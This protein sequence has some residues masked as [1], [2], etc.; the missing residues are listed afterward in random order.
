MIFSESFI[1]NDG[2][3]LFNRAAST[4]KSIIWGSVYTS[5]LDS[6]G[7][8]D[9][10]MHAMTSANFGTYTSSGSVTS[11]FF[12]T[13]SNISHIYCDLNNR[14]YDGVARTLGIWAKI[15]GDSQSVL[16]VVAR[17]GTGTV[18]TTV[19]PI[20]RGLLRVQVD[21]SITFTD[22]QAQSIEV[23][24]GYYAPAQALQENNN[25][26]SQIE[27]D[28]VDLDDRVTVLEED[29]GP[30]MTRFVS[31]HAQ[32]S[33]T[34]GDSQIIY[35]VKTFKD[36]IKTLSIVPDISAG[37][38]LGGSIGDLNVRFSYLFVDKCNTNTLV[39][40]TN[41]Y[42]NIQSSLIPIDNHDAA[43]GLGKKSQDV[44]YH[45]KDSDYYFTHAYIDTVYTHGSILPI[46][47]SSTSNPDSSIGRAYNPSA[48]ITS[49]TYLKL[50]SRGV[51]TNSIYAY[52]YSTGSY[53]GTS[54]VLSYKKRSTIQMITSTLNLT[55][56]GIEDEKDN[57]SNVL[58]DTYDVNIWR[59]PFSAGNKDCIYVRAN[60]SD[61]SSSSTWKNDWVY[62]T[63]IK[64]QGFDLELDPYTTQGGVQRGNGNLTLKNGIITL[65]DEGGDP[66]HY[67]S[68]SHSYEV[69]SS[70]SY[71]EWLNISAG[72]SAEYVK[73][74]IG[75]VKGQSI[76]NIGKSSEPFT[77]TY[78]EKLHIVYYTAS[79]SSS[80]DVQY[81]DE[82]TTSTQD[83]WLNISGK[84]HLTSNEFKVGNYS[85]DN[86]NLHF[87]YSND[88]LDIDKKV[89]LDSLATS[90]IEGKTTSGVIEIRRSL[91]PGVGYNVDLGNYIYH[92]KNIYT[93]KLHIYKVGNDSQ[94]DYTDALL[95]IDTDNTNLHTSSSYHEN[96]K[97]CTRLAFKSQNNLTVADSNA[98]DYVLDLKY[99]SESLSL[100]NNSTVRV[101]VG[102]LIYAFPTF[103][104]HFPVYTPTGT[105]LWVSGTGT[106]VINSSNPGSNKFSFSEAEL[107]CNNN[108]G[109]SNGSTYW[110]KV[111]K[112][113]SKG[114]YRL[115][116]GAGHT[117][118]GDL[119]SFNIPF[120]L[121]KIS[122]DWEE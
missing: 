17:C 67:V 41:N 106:D 111:S 59:N 27:G 109:T 118:L 56:S 47:S 43:I 96:G 87:V 63:K 9:E 8:S 39:S 49:P 90:V 53:S 92:Y 55:L 50:Y 10:V 103:L 54:S 121:Q 14:T 30:D 94:K 35:G 28:V 81:K 70:N 76:C 40:A 66:S 110:I 85:N 19:N 25:R 122:D 102:A 105:V 68:L 29:S 36:D 21:V 88:S 33:A 104:N 26:L 101:C 93:D 119:V 51:E 44:L 86:D 117:S 100:E 3:S 99:I 83:L 95:F 84:V 1:T 82:S 22:Y 5:S 73:P 61:P 79:S 6:D 11:S 57:N 97:Y 58:L 113:L 45:I 89:K 12:D 114:T 108:G 18:P 37:G 116:H 120:L 48:T 24:S 34:T 2:Y 98:N 91:V 78:L 16:V 13:S 20:S 7:F 46:S 65:G 74:S 71:R 72:L 64:V 15:Q 52:I 75:I 115:L 38:S 69:L 60:Q 77:N 62:A 107:F 80:C 31:C 32:G 112:Y 4:N 23:I 42:I